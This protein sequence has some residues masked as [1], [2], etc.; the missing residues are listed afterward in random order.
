MK[1]DSPRILLQVRKIL[2]NI[3]RELAEPNG[4]ITTILSNIS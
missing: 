3:I 4:E 1:V 2:E